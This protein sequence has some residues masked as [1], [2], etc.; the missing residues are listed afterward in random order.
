M[1][2]WKL[3]I[4]FYLDNCGE[5]EHANTCGTHCEPT[6]QVPKHGSCIDECNDKCFCNKGF[7]RET[8]NG[9]CIPVKNCPK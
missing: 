1:L 2:C 6:C 7:I 4:S 5:N 9:K 3:K 8:E